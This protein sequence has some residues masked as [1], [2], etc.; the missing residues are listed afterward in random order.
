MAG[1]SENSPN[2]MDALATVANLFQEEGCALVG[3]AVDFL[4]VCS[5]GAVQSLLLLL[6]GAGAL[7]DDCSPE[8]KAGKEGQE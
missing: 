3:V 7:C 4:C 6:V 1:E 2:A 8:P 5:V